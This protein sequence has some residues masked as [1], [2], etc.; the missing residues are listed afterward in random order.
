[1]IQILSPYFLY[2]G[3]PLVA[4]A[5]FWYWFHYKNPVYRFSSL[6]PLETLGSAATW[7]RLVTF[8]LRLATLAS[9]CFALAR[10]QSPDERS[11]ISVQGVDIMLVLDVSESMNIHDDD[12]EAPARID[13]ARAEALKFIDKR[14]ND[15]IGLVLFSG[16]P[17][18]RCPLTLDKG[19]LKEML[20]GTTTST[21]AVPGTV[22][23]RAILTAAN[24]LKKSTA[25]SRIMIVLTDGEPTENDIQPALAIELAKKLGIKIYTIGIG[26]ER[27][28]WVDHPVYGM[29]Q[30]QSSLNVPLL[31][32]F[33]SETGGQFFLARNADDMASIYNT[34]DQLERTEHE[35]PLFARY[36]EYFMPFLWLAFL[37]LMIEIF[38]TSV[39]WV[40]L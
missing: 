24:R 23:S 12:P 16:A 29:I 35:T 20:M 26:G 27:A 15:P 10:F 34:I 40:R 32:K 25:K 4:L 14:D 6:V 22:L 31:E 37:L 33:A 11:K 3:L 38:L 2:A 1:M 18:S 21:I 30:V 39:W 8:L 28:G 36:F 7:Y 13:I 5:A 19:V 17:V 9:L